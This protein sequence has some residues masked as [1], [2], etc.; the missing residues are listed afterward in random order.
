VGPDADVT[1]LER[2]VQPG[3]GF[4]LRVNEAAEL[5]LVMRSGLER[6]RARIE[7][8]TIAV[9][10]HQPLP[11]APAT[12]NDWPPIAAYSVTRARPQA[13]VAVQSQRG[14]PLV[15]FHTSG[16]GRVVAVT[17]GLGRWTP[18]WTQWA[19]WPR[20]AGGLTDWIGGTAGEGTFGLA[21]SDL[22]D[23]LQVDADVRSAMGWSHPDGLSIAATIP[24][25]GSR[26]VA[27]DYVAP[28]RLRAKLPDAGA[29]LYTFAVSSPLGTKRL[30]H[31]RRNRAEDESRGTNPALE[32]WRSAGLITN[33]APGSLGQDRQT[34]R[35]LRQPDRWLIGLALAAF[36][37]GILVD[38]KMRYAALGQRTSAELTLRRTL[39]SG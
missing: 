3:A 12:L 27:A 16:Q 13:T 35:V 28:G 37:A 18:Q 21:V 30:L 20:L 31:L 32:E 5:P 1:A 34:S 6:R 17:S 38:R 19:E 26:V 4:V 33:W 9:K 36:L 8:G 15:A 23:G 14:D 24:V 10:Q 7:R 25:L 11:F 2:L 29:L 39:S 22:P